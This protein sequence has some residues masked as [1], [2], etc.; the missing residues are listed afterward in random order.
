MDAKMP[1]LNSNIEAFSIDSFSKTFSSIY[2][3]Y[4]NYTEKFI[5]DLSS[6][7]SNNGKWYFPINILDLRHVL[8]NDIIYSSSC[9]YL[10]PMSF[11]KKYLLDYGVWLE[12]KL[13]DSNF[14]KNILVMN[15]PLDISKI[16]SRIIIN[17]A[18]ISEE[19]LNL[20]MD[21]IKS[22]KK[23]ENFVSFVKDLNSLKSYKLA[24]VEEKKEYN[25]E[26]NNV[27]QNILDLLRSFIA[28]YRQQ[29]NTPINAY[30]VGGFVRDKLMG[31]YSDD[32]DIAVTHL[33][34]KSFVGALQTYAK[35]NNIKGVE[36]TYSTLLSKDP[37]KKALASEQLEVSAMNLFGQKVEFV[38]LRKE[39]YNENSRTP[40]QEMTNDPKIDAQ[41]R[42]LTINSIYYNIGDS[43]IED[44]TGG[45][46]DLG[47]DTG[48][49]VLRTP[50]DPVKTLTEDPLRTL[51]ILRFHSRY[52]NSTIEPSI[53]SAMASNEVQDA[54]KRIVKPER[55]SKELRKMMEE[56]NPVGAT[57]ILFDTKLYQ[58]VFLSLVKDKENL[59]EIEVDQSTPHHDLN[60]KEHTLEVMRNLL[61]MAKTKGV[62]KTDRGLLMMSSL[63][64]D[65]GKMHKN[66]RK[67]KKK[68]D[69]EDVNKERGVP[70]T[71]D[72][73]GVPVPHYTY[74]NH[75]SV[76][77]DMAEEI[78]E[79]M[80]FSPKEKKF[81]KDIVYYHMDPHDLEKKLNP[82][83]VGRILNK[84]KEFDEYLFMHA[85]ADALSKNK[86]GDHLAS[87]NEINSNRNNLWNSVKQYK[88]EMGDL[89]HR[90]L[91][92]GND[93]RAIA[94]KN[95]PQLEK[96]QARFTTKSTGGK[97]QHYIKYALDALITAQWERKVKDREGAEFFV[98]NVLKQFGNLWKSQISPNLNPEKKAKNLFSIEKLSEFKKG[99]EVR[100]RKNGLDEE[101]SIG[102]IFEIK[103]NKIYIDWQYGK[104]K[105]KKTSHEIDN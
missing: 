38:N 19:N 69:P 4:E 87:D 30:L 96:E 68:Y 51:R 63:M 10:M 64:H 24:Q 88:A 14:D 60:L 37:D 23:D 52:P 55:A 16:L 66:I 7:F 105:G 57:K 56:S 44:F 100:V 91:L 62:S 90:P 59:H 26:F 84:V 77:A 99:D 89:I 45:I 65:F 6:S 103:N 102:R 83:V 72:R 40:V 43:K 104:Y 39:T 3:S 8:E 93:V 36:E 18:N 54:Y 73:N 42:D 97:P 9:I 101:H 85:H 28:F 47:L 25:L 67:M 75:Q 71:F 50:D 53:I 29:N 98:N 49:V 86:S 82:K 11:A 33:T 74:V 5:E 15:S 13:E 80:G 1:S 95:F 41:R 58:S 32:I 46:K 76:S 2:Y 48:K 31:V 70:V 22:S 17:K 61:D 94:V 20:V 92:D 34:G 79:K 27:E 21:L 12:L 35:T 81:V 78:M